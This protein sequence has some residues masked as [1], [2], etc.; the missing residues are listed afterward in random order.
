MRSARLC[1]ISGSPRAPGLAK[2]RAP[3]S[4]SDRDLAL[5]PWRPSDLDALGAIM[6]DAETMEHTGGALTEDELRE[7]LDRYVA[8]AAGPERAPDDEDLVAVHAV[9]HRGEVVGS[10]DIVRFV[11]ADGREALEIGYA[12][13]RDRWRQGLGLRT[14]RLILEVARRMA[15][16]GQR[17]LALADPGHDASIGVLTRIGLIPSGLHHDEDGD[18]LVYV[19][20]SL[21]HDELAAA[22]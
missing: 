3:V 19:A 1:R 5:R 14:A 10:A 18:V 17:V 22:E 20:P 4:L 6:C 12:I 8:R 13:R 21:G 15:R 16:R 7:M 9:V 11:G 2:V